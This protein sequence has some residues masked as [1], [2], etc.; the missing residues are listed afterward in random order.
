MLNL[1]HIDR[2]LDENDQNPFDVVLTELFL[3]DFALGLIHK[4][5]VPFIRFSWCALPQF[6]YDR[7][8]MPDIPAYIPFAFSGFSFKMNF[9]ERIINWLTAKLIRSFAIVSDSIFLKYMKFPKIQV[10][11]LINIIHMLC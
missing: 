2:I 1:P 8:S 7:V 9:S 11:L 4:L 3:P 10:P 6:I 5:N